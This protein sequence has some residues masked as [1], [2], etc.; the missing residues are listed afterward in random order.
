MRK[1]RLNLCNFSLFSLQAKNLSGHE[2]T[3]VLGVK[4]SKFRG[5]QVDLLSL[6]HFL[7]EERKKFSKTKITKNKG[8]PT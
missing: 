5:S 3:L 6:A 8:F 1:V 2:S 7:K 4:V